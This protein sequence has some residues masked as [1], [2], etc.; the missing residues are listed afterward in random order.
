M[1]HTDKNEPCVHSELEVRGY[2]YLV[3]Q[4]QGEDKDRSSKALE[5]MSYYSMEIL[6][7]EMSDKLLHFI[8][9]SSTVLTIID[10]LYIT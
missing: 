8:L 6:I 7:L 9:I 1:L 2:S 5:T 3:H 4:D 10:Y